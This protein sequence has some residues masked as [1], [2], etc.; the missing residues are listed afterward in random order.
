MPCLPFLLTEIPMKAS[1]WVGGDTGPSPC[2]PV[3]FCLYTLPSKGGLFELVAGTVGCSGG[4]PQLCPAS[5]LGKTWASLSLPL[6]SRVPPS[7]LAPP[8][9]SPRD[10][11][12]C[13]RRDLPSYYG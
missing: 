6:N 3:F 12:P 11:G 5:L 4:V 1:L 9:N 10:M 7:S 8:T 13:L 2:L